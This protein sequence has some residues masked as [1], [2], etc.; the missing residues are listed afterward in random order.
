VVLFSCHH[1]QNLQVDRGGG[2]LEAAKV[3]KL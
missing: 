2:S 3:K 1:Q